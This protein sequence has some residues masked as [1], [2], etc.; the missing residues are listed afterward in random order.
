VAGKVNQAMSVNGTNGLSVPNSPS[1]NFGANIDFSIDAWIKTSETTRNTLTIVDKR[2]ITGA[3]VTGY[4]VYL[5]NGRLGLQLGVGG[6]G[7]DY[8]NLS[9]DLRNGQWHHIAITVDRDLASGGKAYVDGGQTGTFNPTARSG[10]L[11]NTQP[12]LIGKHET[13]PV[14]N[15]IGEIDEVELFNRAIT[16]AEVASIYN[17]GSTG[18]CH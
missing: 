12:F 11:T 10:N 17:A 6:S 8:I 14:A 18:K 15:F 5:F 13:A 2:Q 16:G 3:N 1:L 9:A 7:Q 4:V